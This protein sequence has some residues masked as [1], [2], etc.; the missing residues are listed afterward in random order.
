M[1]KVLPHNPSPFEHWITYTL[2]KDRGETTMI[3]SGQNGG[4]FIKEI[5]RTNS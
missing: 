1:V 4:T 2:T 3:D 5:A